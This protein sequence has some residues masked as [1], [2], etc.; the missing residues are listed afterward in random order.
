MQKVTPNSNIQPGDLV[1]AHSRGAF[2]VLIRFGQWLRPSWRPW[3]RWNHT[4]IVVGIRNDGKIRCMQMGRRG[5]IVNIEEVS[6]KGY[7]IV[8]PCPKGVDRVKAV[9]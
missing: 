9:D 2:A 4:A 3:K 1:L 8:R 7:Y 5:E 6:P